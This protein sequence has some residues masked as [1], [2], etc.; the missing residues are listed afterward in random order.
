MVNSPPLV[1]QQ[2]D[3]SDQS[4]QN[5][6]SPIQL[7]QF[8]VCGLGS[9]GQHC[10]AALK[11]FGIKV[12]TIALS[13]PTTWEIPQIPDLL[14][15]LIV[16]DCREQ[17][18]LEQ[19]QIHKYR[20]VLLVTDSDRT[21]AEAAFAIRSLNPD[22]RLVVRSEQEN[23]N[24]LLGEALGNFIAFEP[25]QLPATAFAL[26]AIGSE[27]AGFFHLE[28]QS[29]RVVNC[30]ITPDHRW[31]NSRLVHELDSRNRRIL[32]HSPQDTSLLGFYAWHPDA[33]IRAGDRVVYLEVTDNFQ[34]SFISS[35]PNSRNRGAKSKQDKWWQ[36]G[37]YPK[38]WQH[39]QKSLADW[40]SLNYQNQIYRVALICGITVVILLLVGTGL[41]YFYYPNTNFYNSFLMTAIL[42]LGGYADLYG[43]FN[44]P[45]VPWWFRLLGLTLTLAGTAFVGVIYALLT[46]ALLS[47]RFQFLQPRPPVPLQNHVVLIGLDAVGQKV[48]Q[49]LQE[50][51]QPFVGVNLDVNLEANIL[52][53]M[54]L[55]SGNLLQSLPKANL[56]TA[57]SV[58]AI[59]NDEM[60]N[61][62]VGLMARRTNP[63]SHLVIRTFAQRLSHN[64]TQLL[65]QSHILCAYALTAEAFAGA[66]F[67]EKILSL[68][69]LQNQTILVTEYNIEA[70]DT[71][72][73]LLLSEVAYG[74]GVVPILATTS[75]T[76]TV[77][78]D[79]RKLMP[80]EDL[81]LAA[82]DRL[83]VLA[84][85][86]GLRRIEQGWLG[87]SPKQWRVQVDQAMNSNAAFEGANL[88]A[89]I[90]GCPLGMARDLMT[91]LPGVLRSPLYHHQA[92][93]LVRE[94]GRTQVNAQAIEITTIN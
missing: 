29:L 34:D 72:C 60:L 32:F 7:D 69:R 77:G 37:S 68:F 2:S 74:Y 19:A 20:A 13:T 71:L 28:G 79:S 15:Q 93:R 52:P 85:I 44:E 26:A 46:Q 89:R 51:Q 88:M 40:W 73:G 80:P 62:E 16:G 66:A 10:V 36:L 6:R 63:Q 47:S 3:Q 43:N 30:L 27:I 59:T 48:A 17:K 38:A 83:V 57:K 14:E 12:T 41:F 87:I 45:S 22:T 53:Q 23:L 49:L 91:N 50:F 78:A 39:W 67:G 84:T 76:M 94:L 31:C 56:A 8:L 55:V 64:L 5:D 58:I 11:E 54:P 4:D 61:L 21:N 82:G 75:A 65:P 42:L 92:L 35:R 1:S 24:Q 70:V 90:T 18:F 81:R 86:D 33:V 25:T 9:L